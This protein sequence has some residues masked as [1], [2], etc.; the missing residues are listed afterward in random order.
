MAT[1]VALLTALSLISGWP[2]RPALLQFGGDT[3]RG[4]LVNLSAGARPFDPPDPGRPTVVFIHGMNLAPRL[5]HFTMAQR[6]AEA[7]ASRG[8][9][10]LNVFDWNWNGATFVGLTSDANESSAVEQGRILAATLWHAGIPPGWTHLVGHSSG[11]IVAASAA[12][13]LAQSSGQ[14]IAQLT[15]LDAANFYHQ[16]VFD[17]LA[18]GASA[19]LVENHWAPGPSGYGGPVARPFVWNTRVDGPTPYLG[20]FH[21]FRSSHFHVVEWYVATAGNPSYPGGFNTSLIL[22]TRSQ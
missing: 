21:P 16:L 2:D 15:L 9:P 18:A 20:T 12:R 10:P 13:T 7:I 3:T 4:A 19:R 11:S 17:V 8:G 22:A 1:Q 5:V 6:L 14:P